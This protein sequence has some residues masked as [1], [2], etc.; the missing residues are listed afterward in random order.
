MATIEDADHDIPE[1]AVKALSEAQEKAKKSGRPMIL[2]EDGTLVERLPD[3]TVRQLKKLP[4]RM[5]V[6]QRIKKAKS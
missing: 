2:V 6:N 5:K 3:G 1:L 4:A